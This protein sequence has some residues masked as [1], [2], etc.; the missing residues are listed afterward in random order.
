M[1][2]ATSDKIFEEVISAR[3]DVVDDLKNRLPPD[4][5]I[6]KLKYVDKS[7]FKRVLSDITDIRLKESTLSVFFERGVTLQMEGSSP[8][9]F[10]NRI[11]SE[12]Y[13][14]L[15]VIEEL[16]TLREIVLKTSPFT[17][18]L[19]PSSLKAS[20]GVSLDEDILRVPSV[21]NTHDNGL[22]CWGGWSGPIRS[23][24]NLFELEQSLLLMVQRMRQLNIDDYA[25]NAD[26]IA[27]LI[28]GVYRNVP[29]TINPMTLARLIVEYD[30]QD[31]VIEENC[32]YFIWKGNEVYILGSVRT[33][34]KAD[35]FIELLRQFRRA[36]DGDK[37]KINKKAVTRR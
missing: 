35:V 32:K 25:G 10:N 33:D 36:H 28:K 12:E 7:F 30:L 31:R 14:S 23:H 8:E 15:K 2:R 37:P 34:I 11:D 17:I 26:R 5:D 16:V 22:N 9:A 13:R 3:M 29:L 6:D 18:D 21:V 27:V 20:Y 1:D 19:T 4:N 24:F